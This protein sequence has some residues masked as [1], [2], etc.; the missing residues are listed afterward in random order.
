MP[1]VLET[2][3]GRA[4]TVGL[5]TVTL[6]NLD[7]VMTDDEAGE[8]LETAWQSGIRHF[9]TAPHYGLGLAERRLGAFLRTKPRGEFVVSTKVGRL[10]RPDPEGAGRFDDEHHYVVPA[11]LKRVWDLSAAGVRRSLEESLERL[12]LDAVDVLYLHDPESH[13]LRQGITEALPEL[14][15]MR[16]E[17][18]VAAVGVGSMATAALL[19]GVGHGGLDLLMVA[20]RW[21]LADQS[22]GEEVL[23]AC[24]KHGTAVVAAA[25]FNSGLLASDSPSTRDRFDY[26]PVDDAVLARVQRLGEVCA[27]H[28]VPLRTA[29]LQY[30]LQHPAVR[31]VVVGAATPDQVRENLARLAAPVPEELWGALRD[32]GLVR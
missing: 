23:P 11:D 18:V 31:A 24:E 26:G 3:S 25:V 29:A 17:G 19:A 5:G 14:L 16:D 32:E 4:G 9:D 8:L 1:D 30:P 12:G 15:T 10:L 13:D 2:A 21:T 28:D 22:A 20:G 27:A 7:R 6:G